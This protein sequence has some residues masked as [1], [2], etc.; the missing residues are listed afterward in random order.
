MY[1]HSCSKRISNLMPRT[2]EFNFQLSLIVFVRI[3]HL[4]FVQI[5]SFVVS[6]T[7]GFRTLFMPDRVAYKFDNM[8][9]WTEIPILF[10]EF[11]HT[12]L[13]HAH[14]FVARLLLAW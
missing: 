2:F 9:Y 4:A 10:I 1:K 7:S 6:L 12:L 3:M 5:L 13:F 8:R 11:L 14:E